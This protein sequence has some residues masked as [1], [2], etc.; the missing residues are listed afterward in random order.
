MKFKN[1]ILATF[2]IMFFMSC[3]KYTIQPVVQHVTTPSG[4]GGGGGGT[5]VI[6]FSADI[7]PMFTSNC[8]SCHD[9]NSATPDL[10]VGNAYTELW[11]NGDLDSTV[12]PENN[13]LYKYLIGTSKP[14][15]SSHSTPA[16]NSNVLL[17][18]QQGAK[19]N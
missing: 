18:I 3:V 8:V 13:K 4:G 5:T 2:V 6:H 7:Q 14:S 9:G 12:T 15:M 17:W 16:F 11:A 1:L 10:T 19:N